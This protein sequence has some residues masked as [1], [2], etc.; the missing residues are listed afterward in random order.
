MIAVFVI[1]TGAVVKSPAPC[2]VVAFVALSTFLV[3]ELSTRLRRPV[4][5][6]EFQMPP[7]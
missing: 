2:L 6:G 4:G 7:P 1:D 3:I 5:S